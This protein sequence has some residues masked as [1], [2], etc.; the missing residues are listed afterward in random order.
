MIMYTNVM[1]IFIAKRPI[2]FPVNCHVFDTGCWNLLPRQSFSGL[3]RVVGHRLYKMAYL[4]RI[5]GSILANI[6]RIISRVHIR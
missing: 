5:S 2:T 1:F 3:Q 4:G 6:L